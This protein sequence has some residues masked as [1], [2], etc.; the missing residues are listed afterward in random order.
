MGFLKRVEIIV[1]PSQHE[2]ASGKPCPML[3]VSEPI[4]H[5]HMA[6]LKKMSGSW[7]AYGNH[8]VVDSN[9]TG[10]NVTESIVWRARHLIGTE[11]IDSFA[12]YN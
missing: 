10:G 7:S 8:Q 12:R 1:Y 3:I 6:Q 9:R 2:N 4:N 11:G 5:I